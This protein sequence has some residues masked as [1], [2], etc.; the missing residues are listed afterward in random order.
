MVCCITAVLIHTR[1][2]GCHP[3]LAL[4][5]LIACAVLFNIAE[6]YLRTDS[7]SFAHTATAIAAAWVAVI[8]GAVPVVLLVVVF[9]AR[10]DTTE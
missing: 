4:Q 2:L 9:L 3:V 6:T 8:P 7:D 10:F 5:S 1:V